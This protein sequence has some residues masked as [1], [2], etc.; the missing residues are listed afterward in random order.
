MAWPNEHLRSCVSHRQRHAKAQRRAGPGR[1]PTTLAG[2]A[3]PEVGVV[4][5]FAQSVLVH[6]ERPLLVYNVLAALV[7]PSS[8]RPHRRRRPEIPCTGIP[9]SATR[10]A[11]RMLEEHPVLAAWFDAAR[12]QQEQNREVRP[13]SP[14]AHSALPPAATRRNCVSAKSE[15][16]P[17]SG[18]Q[19]LV[20][21]SKGAIAMALLC[22]AVVFMCDQLVQQSLGDSP[23]RQRGE[24]EWVSQ[25]SR[26]P[27]PHSRV[28]GCSRLCGLSAW[29]H[30]YVQGLVGGPLLFRLCP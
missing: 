14:R 4:R 9:A 20:R 21:M 6:L 15:A 16:R 30:R 1:R 13:P 29:R 26:E 2:A 22:P 11:P 28:S 5:F 3:A 8:Q 7:P 10:S 27:L 12:K 17:D 18:G 25:R 24:E 23:P 19:S